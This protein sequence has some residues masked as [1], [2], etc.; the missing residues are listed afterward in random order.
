M[1]KLTRNATTMYMGDGIYDAPALNAAI[2]G[3]ALGQST[4]VT[5]EAAIAVI[6]ESSL[7]K[8]DEFSRRRTYPDA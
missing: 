4:D 1:R 3:L 6:L 8:V 2:V 7:Q 5:A